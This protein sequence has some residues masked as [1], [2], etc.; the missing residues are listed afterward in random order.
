[1]P[2][3]MARTPAPTPAEAASPTTLMAPSGMAVATWQACLTPGTSGQG[4]W[5]P[6]AGDPSPASQRGMSVTGGARTTRAPATANA[7]R[8]RRPLLLAGHIPVADVVGEAVEQLGG[9]G[10]QH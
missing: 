2:S 6:A 4:I 8:Q 3:K 10:G 1:M 7:A 9:G 5:A